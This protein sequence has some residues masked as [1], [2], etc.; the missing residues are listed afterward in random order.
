VSLDLKFNDR[1]IDW[2]FLATNGLCTY[3]FDGAKMEKTYLRD[4]K[5]L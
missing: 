2:T 4:L 5:K 3:T 1:G